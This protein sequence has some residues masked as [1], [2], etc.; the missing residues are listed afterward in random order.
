MRSADLTGEPKRSV[1]TLVPVHWKFTRAL[2]S[3]GK[4]PSRGKTPN[5]R[6][7]DTRFEFRQNHYFLRDRMRN[8]HT[9]VFLKAFLPEIIATPSVK[10]QEFT[11]V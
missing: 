11:Q 1:V 5:T 4:L 6:S 9:A 2:H 8:V 3:Y 10:T 7:E